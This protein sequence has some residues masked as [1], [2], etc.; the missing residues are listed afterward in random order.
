MMMLKMSA[1]VLF[2][3]YWLVCAGM[4][5]AQLDKPGDVCTP[6]NYQPEVQYW[7]ELAVKDKNTGEHLDAV[8]VNKDRRFEGHDVFRFGLSSK[9][10]GYLYLM[11]KTAGGPS[12]SFQLVFPEKVG[13]DANIVEANVPIFIPKVRWYQFEGSHGEEQFKLVFLPEVVDAQHITEVLSMENSSWILEDLSK[14]MQAPSS[15]IAKRSKTRGNLITHDLTPKRNATTEDD[16]PDH[17]ARPLVFEFA[18]KFSN[19]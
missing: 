18:L 2:G 6:Q 11:H 8:K 19:N 17:R 7:I 5:T 1:T 13:G 10:S 16:T 14:K 4:A 3:L 9:C 12:D 15:L